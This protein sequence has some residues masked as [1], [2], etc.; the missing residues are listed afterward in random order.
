MQYF[1]VLWFL[2]KE[3]YM[4]LVTVKIANA[5]TPFLGGG[6]SSVGHMWI[7]LRHENGEKLSYGFAPKVN[8]RAIG[9]GKVFDNDDQQYLKVYHKQSFHISEQEYNTLKQF[10]NNPN[11]YGFSTYNGLVNSCVDF[12]WTALRQ[13]NIMPDKSRDIEGDFWPSHNNKL[14]DEAYYHHY[15]K[16]RFNKEEKGRRSW[17]KTSRNNLENE[18]SHALTADNQISSK[19]H[20]YI[21]DHHLKSLDNIQI[22]D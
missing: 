14:I 19:T 18:L 16:P 4:P 3:K 15:S 10:S 5:G 13:V 17:E 1:N 6:E 20:P 11:Q 12:T 22:V 9:E 21:S 8:G 7:S 2:K